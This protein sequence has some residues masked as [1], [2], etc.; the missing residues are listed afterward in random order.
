MS[1]KGVEMKCYEFTQQP[2]HRFQLSPLRA[3][4]HAFRWQSQ[5]P[6]E[7]KPHAAGRK[8]QVFESCS[9]C[10]W[11]YLHHRNLCDDAGMAIGLELDSAAA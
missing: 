7:E 6:Q 4:A 9:Y 8:A 5:E 1:I 10:I 3:A 11:H 2:N